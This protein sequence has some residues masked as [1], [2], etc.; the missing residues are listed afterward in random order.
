MPVI[1]DSCS[2][3]RTNRLSNVISSVAATIEAEQHQQLQ[4]CEAG[5]GEQ[6]AGAPQDHHLRCELMPLAV[7]TREPTLASCTNSVFQICSHSARHTWPFLCAKLSEDAK[8][9]SD[10]RFCL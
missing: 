1:C 2:G 5:F 3:E 10:G 6:S 8:L 7:L 4:P 9:A